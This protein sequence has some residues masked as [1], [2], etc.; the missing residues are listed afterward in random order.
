MY[1]RKISQVT[2][3]GPALNS[4]RRS[5]R[6]G[7]KGGGLGD[8]QKDTQICWGRYLKPNG[9]K[10]VAGNREDH[11]FIP[12]ALQKYSTYIIKNAGE[13]GVHFFDGYAGLKKHFV[14]KMYP[15]IVGKDIPDITTNAFR[16]WFKK[17]NSMIQYSPE[18]TPKMKIWLRNKECTDTKAS[19]QSSVPSSS[20]SSQ[21][22]LNLSTKDTEATVNSSTKDTQTTVALPTMD[23]KY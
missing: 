9:W 4:R 11:I 7:A 12:V 17:R 1:K 2:G 14:D 16:N 20:S 15:S 3:G 13:E 6:T 22:T 19:G 18:P 10:H 8:E 21:T 23:N 5:V